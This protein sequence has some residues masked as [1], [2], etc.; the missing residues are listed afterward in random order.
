MKQA[1]CTATVTYLTVQTV[2]QCILLYTL[3]CQ[4]QSELRFNYGFASIVIV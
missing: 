1:N 2:V 4:R 3:V